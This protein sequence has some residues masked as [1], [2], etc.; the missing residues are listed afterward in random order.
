MFW[1]RNLIWEVSRGPCT[2]HIT[3]TALVNQVSWETTIW[4]ICYSQHVSRHD[5]QK[6]RYTI[7][8]CFPLILLEVVS[9]EVLKHNNRSQN[10]YTN[11]KVYQKIIQSYQDNYHPR[12]N[13]LINHYSFSTLITLLNKLNDIYWR[14]NFCCA[15][16]NFMMIFFSFHGLNY[17][18]QNLSKSIKKYIRRIPI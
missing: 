6:R 15:F 1:I 8:S 3:H 14:Q 4:K 10:K 11:Q 18:N 5:E 9:Q 12:F 17:T 2:F 16:E 7:L 13:F